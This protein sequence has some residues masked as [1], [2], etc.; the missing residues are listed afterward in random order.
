[1]CDILVVSSGHFYMGERDTPGCIAC[2]AIKD[3]RTKSIVSLAVPSKGRDGYTEERF[4]QALSFFGYKKVRLRTDQEP[5][6]VA[7]V[8]DVMSHWSGEIMYENS[9]VGDHRANGW[10]E[11]G[12]RTTGSR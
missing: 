10:I 12:I 2:L 7:L 11:S 6:L 1:M 9:P 5:S 4:V 3:A 8:N